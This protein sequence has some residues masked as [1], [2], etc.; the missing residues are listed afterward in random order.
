MKML[1]SGGVSDHPYL[2]Q[3][4]AFFDAIDLGVFMRLTSLDEPI[5]SRYAVLAAD[6]SS[7]EKRTV[8]LF[9]LN[10]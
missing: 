5:Q 2:S 9:E 8:K 7:R 6:L 3:F 4:K 10:G 1:D